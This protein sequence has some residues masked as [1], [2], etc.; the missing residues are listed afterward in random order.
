MCVAFL[1][2]A[3]TLPA[4]A[5]WLVLRD[6][7][8]LEGEVVGE[9]DK[10]LTVETWGIGLSYTQRVAKAKVKTWYRP[11]RDGQPYVV[12]PISGTIGDD[13]TVEALAAGLREARAAK[14]K[15]VI[16]AIDS[17]G[18][19]VVEMAGMIE[20]LRE[21]SKDVAIVAYVKRA[22]SA[23]AV[24]AMSCR[25]VYLRSDATIGATV[26]FRMTQDGPRDVDAKWRSVIE[27][28]MRNATHRG[29][30]PDML[31]RGMS[32]IDLELFLATDENGARSLRT[33]G[34]GKVV[35]AKGQILTLTADE[36]AECGFARVAPTMRELGAQLCGG[37][38]HEV[39]RRAWNVTEGTVAARRRQALEAMRRQQLLAAR[40]IAIARIKPEL[41]VMERRIA[42]LASKSAAAENAIPELNVSYHREV[43]Q[44]SVE[45]EQALAI[46]RYQRDPNAAI[47]RATEV[48]NARAAAAR[49]ALDAT[50]TRLRAEAQAAKVEIVLLRERQNSLIAT[51]PTD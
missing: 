33:S 44:I 20:A 40:A 3:V 42:E 43:W 9:D 8:T 41:D 13:V 22:H 34:P 32:E 38:W 28:E 1:T 49:Q 46:A 36:A 47:A 48:T 26:P 5:D 51:I 29:G 31:I 23:A 15:Y 2:L 14:P 27:A 39:N 24:I 10:T 21:A 16:L 35:K 4:S 11:K 30:H 25:H 12:I 6:G 7:R 17:G 45:H 37:A 50:T 18:G 19:D